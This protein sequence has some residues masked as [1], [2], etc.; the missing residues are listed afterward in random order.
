MRTHVGA[1]IYKFIFIVF[2]A[3]RLSDNTIHKPKTYNYRCGGG[4]TSPKSMPI[5]TYDIILGDTMNRVCIDKSSIWGG[6]GRHVP[7]VPPPP[8]MQNSFQDMRQ[9]IAIRET[10]NCA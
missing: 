10:V 1:K 2:I 3:T 9:A 7:P 8:P 4:S 5:C 6:G